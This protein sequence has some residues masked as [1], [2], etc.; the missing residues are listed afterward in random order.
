META[1]SEAESPGSQNDVRTLLEAALAAYGT[2]DHID[3][4]ARIFFTAS[5]AVSDQRKLQV[6][7]IRAE[8]RLDRAR[9]ETDPALRLFRLEEAA[10]LAKRPWLH[11][12]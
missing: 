4:I 1:P 10:S 6:Q 3:Y 11:G 7:R 5:G 8:V 2:S 9:A 12:P